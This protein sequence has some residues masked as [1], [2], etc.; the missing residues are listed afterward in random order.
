MNKTI[1]HRR[2]LL[3]S[4]ITVALMLSTSTA[5]GSCSS[6]TGA[7]ASANPA[8][9]TSAEP[10]WAP[11]LESPAFKQLTPEQQSKIRAIEAMDLPSFD[12]QSPEDQMAYGAFIREVYQD[13]AIAI[14]HHN[15]PDISLPAPKNVGP[16]STGQEILDDEGFKM[17]TAFWTQG[18]DSTSADPSMDNGKKL[19]PS[20]VH[21]AWAPEQYDRVTE[22]T[23]TYTSSE[24]VQMSRAWFDGKKPVT[25]SRA[26]SPTEAQYDGKTFKVIQTVTEDGS[27]KNQFYFA[28][29][30][31]T[32][33]HGKADGVWVLTSNILES[34]PNWI[35]DLSP[36]Y[37]A[38]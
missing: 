8:L 12:Q 33:I 9:T 6:S 32:D 26:W 19:A 7:P 25:E 34:H 37:P 24:K 23:Q 16:E 11:L 4:T 5:L 36:A 27:S 28:Y 21:R 31:F 18:P 2:A 1:A 22:D 29:V 20:R 17:T 14:T 38:A 3:R 35:P 15:A 10:T 30:P 13:Y